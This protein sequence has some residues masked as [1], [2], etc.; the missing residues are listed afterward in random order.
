[1]SEAASRF[2]LPFQN[3]LAAGMQFTGGYQRSRGQ[4]WSLSCHGEHFAF[5]LFIY[6]FGWVGE[7]GRW[8]IG[9]PGPKIDVSISLK[10]VAITDLELPL[11]GL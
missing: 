7:A 11:T 5:L 3:K 9:R 6:F 10:L 8:Q 1:M 4:S 2:R